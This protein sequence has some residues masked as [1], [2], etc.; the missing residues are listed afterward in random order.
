MT[1]EEFLA[2]LTT[3]KPQLMKYALFFT[4]NKESGNELLQET[5]AHAY[6]AHTKFTQGT[7]F[8]NWM[9]T[10]MKNKHIN[11][12]EKKMNAL[13]YVEYLETHREI[14]NNTPEQHTVVHDLQTFIDGM[15]HEVRD[16]IKLRIQGMSY[17]EIAT[18]LGIPLSTVKNRLF[19]ARIRIKKELGK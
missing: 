15:P 10:I 3:A 11:S 14:E 13:S 6:M 18:I 16:A 4:G 12:S 5:I 7:N 2:E 8:T 17:D 9:A 1:E 19:D